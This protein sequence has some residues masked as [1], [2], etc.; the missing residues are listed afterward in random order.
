MLLRVSRMVDDLRQ[1]AELELSPVLAFPGGV[2]AVDGRIRIQAAEPMD[3][4]LRRLQSH[5]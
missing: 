3:A 2:Q 5:T 1:I 4:H